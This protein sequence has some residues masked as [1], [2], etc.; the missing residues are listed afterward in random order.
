MS[1]S[2]I[3]NLDEVLR[4]N[5]LEDEP[6]KWNYLVE[7]QHCT[8]NVVQAPSG[9]MPHVHKEHD[10]T[11]YCIKGTGMFRL[12]DKTLPFKSGDVVFIPAGT[13]HTPITDSYL[14][15]LSIYS[16]EFD[17]KNP[18]REFVQE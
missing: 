4:D 7:G 12:G 8:I 9:N 2:G 13:I 14:A 5:P 18:D 15:A 11:V 1:Q 3:W 16:P 10:E 17:P 6:M